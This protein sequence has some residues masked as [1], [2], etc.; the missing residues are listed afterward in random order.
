MSVAVLDQFKLKILVMILYEFIRN[1]Y[2][3][4]YTIYLQSPIWM[5]AFKWFLMKDVLED[6]WY[7]G[8]LTYTL[9]WGSDTEIYIP[10]LVIC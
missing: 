5:F 4:P 1:N 9:P 7:L 3:F 6:M 2:I 10:G 8:H